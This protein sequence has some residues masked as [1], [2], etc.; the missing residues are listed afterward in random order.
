MA[1]VCGG[2]WGDHMV[3][4][5]SVRVSVVSKR[6]LRGGLRRTDCQLT[7]NEGEG[8]GEGSHENVTEH[9]E[10]VSKFYRDNQNPPARP[11]LPS[12]PPQHFGYDG[13]IT[14][15]SRTFW[16]ALSLHFLYSILFVVFLLGEH[17]QFSLC[18]R[19]HVHSLLFF[20]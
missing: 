6:V 3:F 13:F 5:G 14:H 7:A 20:P 2:I 16:C 4:R 9:L 18:G 19:L 11:L 12:L 15:F 1:V 8:W 17:V 10:G